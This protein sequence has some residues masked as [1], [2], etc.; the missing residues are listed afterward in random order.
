[1]SEKTIKVARYRSTPYF[2]NYKGNGVMKSYRWA[3]SKEKKNDVQ[4]IPDYVVDY[5][6]MST[7]ALSSGELV[8]EETKENKEIIDNISYEDDYKENINT[9]DDIKKILNKSTVNMEKDLKKIT[10]SSEKKFVIAVAK[11]MKGIM[12]VVSKRKALSEF[13]DVDEEILFAD[14]EG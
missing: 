2:V 3:G 5:L 6:V 11:E 7:S 10:E 13:M 14:V 12:N 4:N 8:V 9:R 1:M